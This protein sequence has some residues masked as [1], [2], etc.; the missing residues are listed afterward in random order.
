MCCYRVIKE[1]TLHLLHYRSLI[2]LYF[3]LFLLPSLCLYPS[4]WT[5][6]WDSPGFPLWPGSLKRLWQSRLKV[7]LE[8]HHCEV[9]LC[10]SASSLLNYFPCNKPGSC[11]AE[12]QA[13]DLHAVDVRRK[14]SV[15]C[16][17]QHDNSLIPA[18]RGTFRS[19][20]K[21]VL[22]SRQNITENNWQSERS[23]SAS[24][25]FSIECKHS[26]GHVTSS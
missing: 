24:E 21:D 2:S 12:W 19:C 6:G 10:S 16:L 22:S 17:Q 20:V 15:T 13:V 9:K 7:Q 25:L 1:V 18:Y 26:G 4:S 14:N 5:P 8:V 11:L 23:W 3:F